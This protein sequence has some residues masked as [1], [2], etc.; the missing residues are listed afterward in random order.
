MLRPVPAGN[1]SVGAGAVAVRR[2]RIDLAIAGG[3][4]AF[5]QIAMPGFYRSRVMIPNVGRLFGGG[6]QGMQIGEAAAFLVLEGDP[7]AR[8]CAQT[9]RV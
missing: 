4:N 6:R 2:D 1:C 9:A 7:V 8:T 3:V 5:S